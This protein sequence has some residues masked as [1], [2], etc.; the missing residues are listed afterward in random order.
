MKPLVGVTVAMTGDF[1]PRR[2]HQ[3]LKRWI[4]KSGGLWSY[5]VSDQVS[6][7]VCSKADY[8]NRV[9]PV[10]RAAKLQN[11][12]IVTYDWLENSIMKGYRHAVHAY[13]VPNVLKADKAAKKKR[14]RVRK[15]NIKKGIAS[16]TESS[17]DNP[18]DFSVDNYHIYIDATA[19][20][21][22]VTLVRVN[23]EENTS[24]RF[25]LKLAQTHDA[26]HYYATLITHH[27]PLRLPKTTILAPIGSDWAT[28]FEGFTLNFAT[29]TGVAWEERL[30][31]KL[32]GWQDLRF[33]YVPPG[34][35]EPRGVL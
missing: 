12:A 13:I 23:V 24:E 19:F 30:G 22:D 18:A 29:I 3:V 14:K 34:L 35:G 5:T 11:I 10:L 21:H 32:E 25:V 1:G 17:T 8:R 26:P 33:V 9:P 7:L 31:P 6:H 28:A 4:L 2:N 15:S 27:H 20:A 16:F